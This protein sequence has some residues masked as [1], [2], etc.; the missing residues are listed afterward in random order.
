MS[1]IDILVASGILTGAV[2]ILYRSIWKKGQCSGCGGCCNM[3]RNKNSEIKIKQTGSSG[4][5]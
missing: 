4:K 1:F 2:Y 3:Q 5:S